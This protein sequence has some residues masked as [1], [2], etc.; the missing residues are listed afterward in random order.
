MGEDGETVETV[1]LLPPW[2][3]VMEYVV[4]TAI[5]HASVPKGGTKKY[6][7]SPQYKTLFGKAH[8]DRRGK[9]KKFGYGP[10]AGK[11]TRFTTI[12]Q[13]LSAIRMM[14][15]PALAASWLVPARALAEGGKTPFDLF[16]A[17]AP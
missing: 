4:K 8:G 14:Y 13:N 1:P 17:E 7:N 10:Y 3:A 15:Q 11:P 2:A 6:R 12:E 9:K 16:Q 5:G